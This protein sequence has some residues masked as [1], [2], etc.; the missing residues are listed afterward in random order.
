MQDK[1]FDVTI[2]TE[3]KYINPTE[4]NAYNKNV[5]LEDDLVFKAL[6]ALDLKVN[7]VAWNDTDFD[8]GITKYA[9]FRTTWDYFEH[10]D[11]FND[12]IKA[13][14]RLTT[15]INSASLIEWNID[16]HYLQDLRTIGIH[17]PKTLFIEPKGNLSLLQAIQEGKEELQFNSDEFVLKPC[18]A[19]GA[20]HTYKFHYSDWEKHD[21]VFQ[22]LVSHETMILQE[23]QKSIVDDGEISMMLF[24]GQFTHAV[25]KKA[26]EGDF[27]VQDDYG[28][29]V[30]IYEATKEQIAFAE[31]VIKACQE[32]PVYARVD[33]F[34]DNEGKLALAEL[35]I[36]EPELWFRL[37]PEAAK[38]FANAIKERILS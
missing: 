30:E 25:V 5:L 11:A 6:V 36:F 9:L 16:K 13:T 31:E 38:L 4:I 8:W 21:D 24:N 2:L 33:I 12:W 3:L 32:K 34:E 17:I 22:K 28:G 35:E 19:A 1:L 18:I 15:F 27:R 7:R 10:I 23:F 14:S 20:R 37:Y 26:K 29:T